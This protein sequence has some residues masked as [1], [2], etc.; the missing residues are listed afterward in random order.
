[1]GSR[2][3]KALKKKG[4][5]VYKVDA[6]KKGQVARKYGLKKGPLWTLWTVGQVVKNYD[7]KKGFIDYF[8]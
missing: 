5:E 7:L 8:H 1:M 4:A 3:K 2:D 6:I